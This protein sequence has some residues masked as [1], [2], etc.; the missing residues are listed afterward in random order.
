MKR[1]FLIS[2]IYTLSLVITGL[3]TLF[4]QTEELAKARALAEQQ[5]YDK[6]KDAYR[7]VRTTNPADMEVYSEYMQLLLKTNDLKTAEKLVQDQSTIRQGHPI[8]TIDKGRVLLAQGKEKKAAEQFDFAV[9]LV[10]GDDIFTQQ[11]ANAFTA[12][13]R[14]D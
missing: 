5:Q 6:A 14:D 7:Q 12:I 8:V 9:Q 2:V 3:P 13:D 4:A 11:I 10:N 1:R